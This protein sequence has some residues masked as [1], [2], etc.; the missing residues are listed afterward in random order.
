MFNIPN[1][2]YLLHSTQRFITHATLSTNPKPNHDLNFILTRD[3]N[4]TRSIVWLDLK[5]AIHMAGY[6]NSI[7]QP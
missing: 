4:E 6:V 7:G 3:I 5:L 1:M 2:I